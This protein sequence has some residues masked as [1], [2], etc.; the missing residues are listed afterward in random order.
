[1]VTLSY[2]NMSQPQNIVLLTISLLLLP[3][4]SL[5]VRFQVKHQRPALIPNTL[6]QNLQFLSI[7]VAMFFTWATFNA[8]QY[9][10]TLF[11]QDIQNSSALQ[12]SIRFLP[13]AVVGV[14]TNMI[15]AYLVS[16]V[17]VNILLGISAI[18][19]AVS[20]ILMAVASPKWTYWTAAF[21]AMILSPVNGDGEWFRP[22]HRIML[23]KKAK[24]EA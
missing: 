5:W 16:R 14:V 21:F 15:A 12:A 9:I 2:K 20:P 24:L 8:F 19:T 18:I 4:F 6:W 17:N 11:F 1:M 13:M 23:L 10:S 22:V 7:C 3:V